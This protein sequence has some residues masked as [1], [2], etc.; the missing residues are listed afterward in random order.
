MNAQA[1]ASKIT[2]FT[3]CALLISSAAVSADPIP[4]TSGAMVVAREQGGARIDARGPG[5]FQ[6]LGSGTFSG[7]RFD[8]YAQCF[9]GLEC[10]P[11][12]DISTYGTWSGVDF[13]GT[14]TINGQTHPMGSLSQELASAVIE[15][16]GSVSAPEFDGRTIREI[17]TPFTFSG[18]VT[19]PIQPGL[20]L[21]YRLV[22]GGTAQLGFRWVVDEFEGAGWMFDRAVYTFDPAAAVPEP[23]SIVLTALGL[24][25]LA[26]RRL[27]RRRTRGLSPPEP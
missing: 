13:T 7:G 21:S 22:G 3:V 2:C 14:L 18:V 27:R 9:L 8:P 10:P 4:I 1:A 19:E 6:L 24:S 15:F 20:G 23:G 11:G 25:G 17:S 5:G 12:T 26:A 16:F